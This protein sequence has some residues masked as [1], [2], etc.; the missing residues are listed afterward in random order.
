MPKKVRNEAIAGIFRARRERVKKNTLN[1]KLLLTRKVFPVPPNSFFVT[2]Y[3]TRETRNFGKFV[4][5][6]YS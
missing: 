1:T 3:K 2:T 4:Q 5:A 6:F